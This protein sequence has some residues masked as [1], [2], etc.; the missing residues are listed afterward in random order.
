MLHPGKQA[1]HESCVCLQD[2][3]IAAPYDSRATEAMMASPREV[4]ANAGNHAPCAIDLND[5]AEALRNNQRQGLWAPAFAAA[6]V[7]AWKHGFAI[8]PPETREVCHQL[9]PSHSEGAGNAGR[10]ARPQPRVQCRQHAR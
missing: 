10:P 5:G 7:R 2:C 4:P 1:H 6:T 8:S 9:A 3:E